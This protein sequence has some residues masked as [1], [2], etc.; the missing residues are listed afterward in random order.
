MKVMKVM[1]LIPI[2]FWS[3][4]FARVISGQDMGYQLSIAIELGR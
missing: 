2:K 3:G 4:N 1:K